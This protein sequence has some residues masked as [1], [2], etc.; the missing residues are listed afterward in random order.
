VALGRSP[1][2]GSSRPSTSV[3]AYCSHSFV[4]HGNKNNQNNE[5]KHSSNNIINSKIRYLIARVLFRFEK[6]EGSACGALKI[7]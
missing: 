3:L 1:G 4:G 5:N 2:I 6:K 7:Y